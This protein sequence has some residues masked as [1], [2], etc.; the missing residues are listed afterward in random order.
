MPL[1]CFLGWPRQK[2]G[3][4][5][6]Y[7]DE[8]TVGFALEGI[9]LLALRDEEVERA[10]RLYAASEALHGRIGYVPRDAVQELAQLQSEPVTS[11][12]GEPAIDKAWAEGETMTTDEAVSYALAETGDTAF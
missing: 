8:A 12:R 4:P 3:R 1:E 7:G 9:A 6:E 10:A 5:H 11:R 2:A